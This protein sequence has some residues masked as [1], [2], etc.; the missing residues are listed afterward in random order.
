M[1]SRLATLVDSVQAGVLVEDEECRILLVNRAFCEM[2]AVPETP[3]ELVDWETRT[4]LGW[5]N[6]LFVD[7][8]GFFPRI[9]RLVTERL[10]VLS[11]E[12]A[13]VDG[14]TLERDYVPVFTDGEYRGHF[15]VFRDITHHKRIEEE[16]RRT[17]ERYRD[18]VE[19]SIALAWSHGLDGTMKSANRA[20]A[21]VFGA[22]SP[23]KV[24][25]LRIQ[26]FI[27][28][29][30][31]GGWEG[32]LQEIEKDG[33][34][35][36]F[37]TLRCRDGA[38]RVLAY[39]NVLRL[40]EDGERVVRGFGADVTDHIRAQQDL[41][42]ANHELAAANRRLEKTNLRMALLN[43]MG[44]LLQTAQEPSEAAGVVESTV[45][46]IFSPFSGGVFLIGSD[47]ESLEPAA[48]WGTP[49][50]APACLRV[51]DCWALR[52]GRPHLSG[53]DLEEGGP[54]CPHAVG[55]AS[56]KTLCV[57]LLAQ[58][59]A[60]GLLYL[61]DGAEGGDAQDDL[62]SMRHLALNTA[63]QLA[64][65]LV[66]LE[67]RE[68]LREQALHDDLTGLFNRRYLEERLD[69]ELRRARR[70]GTP[71]AVLL[72]DLDRF[73]EVNDQHGHAAGDVLLARFA[74]LLQETVRADDVVARYGG[75]EFTVILPSAGA[76]EA[77]KVAEKVRR[78]T[79]RL[80]L[81]AGER[82]LGTVTV[83]VGIA[84]HPDCG[85]SPEEL[86]EAADRALYR[87]KREGRNRVVTAAPDDLGPR[88]AV[89][90]GRGRG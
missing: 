23:E 90:G 5:T 43:E 11:E 53:A 70:S 9:D 44:D 19:N 3:D 60:L 67:L 58:G 61:V 35:G 26:D 88:A 27:D 75:E 87:A 40:D 84:A 77:L 54:R 30:F 51:H 25:G 48:S 34:A 79:Q 73:K 69:Q 33:Q 89:A 50:P 63:E 65:G 31:R 46:R 52:R 39:S 71:L 42:A 13:L 15:W 78:L 82:R 41:E 81:E 6:E 38:P 36:G 14:R 47:R 62:A 57:P 12:L 85:D 22:S 55:A 10:P 8:D 56:A 59:R 83:S 18:F 45:P 7:R 21:Q 28:P 49:G 1:A 16:L 20:L 2:F 86:L 68:S 64:L 32:Y 4:M 24:V 37:V 76:R 80:S 72:L 74:R 66:N 17:A 29:R